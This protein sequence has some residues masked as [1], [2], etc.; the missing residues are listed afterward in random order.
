MVTMT[1]D[2]SLV[3]ELRF[4]EKYIQWD[5]LSEIFSSRHKN[6]LDCTTS[7]V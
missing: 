5:F 7:L 3:P 6:E 4:S 2:N 1:T